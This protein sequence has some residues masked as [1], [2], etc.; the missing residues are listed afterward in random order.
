L[1]F[2]AA[3]ALKAVGDI[4]QAE[5]AGSAA[6][7]QGDIAYQN[8]QATRHQSSANEDT[9]RRRQALQ[10]GQI[11]ANAAESGFQ[12]G[13]GSL[14]ALQTKS[15]GEMELD[16]LTHRYRGELQSIGYQNAGDS[17]RAN[18]ANIRRSG[19]LNAF[20]TLMGGAAFQYGTP[21]I[22]E[23]APVENRD[24]YGDRPNRGGR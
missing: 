24:F 21:R 16:A 23:P 9:L 17:Y 10:M 7:R 22:G 6:N 3:A 19:Y 12:P 13:T 2:I 14:A 18:A 5:S 4:S 8:A 20:G 11:R 15:A 1:T